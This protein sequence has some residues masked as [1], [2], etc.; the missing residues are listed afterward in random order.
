VATF[1]LV[2]GAWHGAWCWFK[3]IPLLEQAG[4]AVVALD[5]P[6]HGIDRTPLEDVSLESYAESVCRALDAC[7]EPVMLVG[8]SMGGV[9]ISRAAE[10]RPAKIEKLVYL[11]AFLLPSGQS[12][13][14]ATSADARAK[15][16]ASLL[17]K[18]D[19]SA[20]SVKAESV[21]HML[22]ADCADSDVALARTLLVPQAMA[23][24]VTPLSTSDAHWGRVPRFYIECTRDNAIPVEAQRAMLSRLPCRRVL[25][26]E[27]SHSPFLSAPGE[28]SAHL[29]QLLK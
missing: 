13:L 24:S 23:V 16:T 12:I 1:V 18:A 19:G 17:V 27:T 11:A 3:V 15:T 14:A 6:S 8:H 28:L 2:H 7:R 20:A 26:L 4:H 5:L 22:Y 9:V 21:R 29:L 10:L 25:T